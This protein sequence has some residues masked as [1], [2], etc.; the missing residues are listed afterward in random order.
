[1][2]FKKKKYN[3]VIK[4]AKQHYE[5]GNLE[6]AVKAYEEAFNIRIALSDY[7]MYG[8]ILIDLQEYSKAE[9]IFMRLPENFDPSVNFALANI[10]ERTNRKEKAIECYEKVVQ[11]HPSFEQAHFSLAYIYD[12][13]S[14]EEKE[15]EEGEHTK[16]AICHYE[17]AI[18][19]NDNNFWSHINLGSI[20]ER[21]NHNEK[22]LKH[23]LR[24]Y[25]I[26]SSKDMVC[27]NLGVVYYKLKKYDE[28]LK[29]Y[30]EELTKENPFKSTYYNL[31][32]LY[33]DGFNDY[34][35][36]KYYYL[37]GLENNNEE[38]NIWYNLGCVHALLEDFENAYQCFKYIYYKNKKYLNYLDTDPELEQFRKTE[39]YNLI[40]K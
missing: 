37:K 15:E 32:I 9:N 4:Q 19:Q 17:E 5:N 25:E 34:E 18:K 23:F 8:Y 30:L 1:M 35:K 7:I 10:Y 39:Y 3:D 36:S 13:I 12:D 20:Y 27:Y 28:S 24:A 33:K 6:K 14:E 21:Y 38:Y 40:K 11:S 31:G 26:D 22:A 29:Y 16:K 2:F